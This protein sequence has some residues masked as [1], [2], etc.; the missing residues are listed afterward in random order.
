MGESLGEGNGGLV[1]E[2][3]YVVNGRRRLCEQ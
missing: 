3:V 1:I 2:E